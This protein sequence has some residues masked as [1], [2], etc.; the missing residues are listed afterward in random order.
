[1]A[2]RYNFI[3]SSGGL[4][5]N[6]GS[7]IR[8]RCNPTLPMRSTPPNQ[9]NAHALVQYVMGSDGWPDGSIQSDTSVVIKYL[10]NILPI[11]RPS[12]TLPPGEW[13]STI[14]NRGQ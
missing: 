12:A 10:L 5:A 7:S 2:F 3:A 13:R 4:L 1:M 6:S 9:I 14:N 11:F 8:G